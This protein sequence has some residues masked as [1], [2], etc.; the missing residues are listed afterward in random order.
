M[1]IAGGVEACSS[2]TLEREE[3][4]FVLR[5]LDADG[6]AGYL[7][8]W[9][10]EEDLRRW[11]E[12]F[13]GQVEGIS[14]PS[15][16]QATPI[17]LKMISSEERQEVLTALY[18]GWDVL[19]KRYDE[20]TTRTQGLLRAFL[21]GG[22]SPPVALRAPTE[23]TVARNLE[24]S[25]RQWLSDS[26]T[27]LYRSLLLLADEAKRLDLPQQAYLQDLLTGAFGMR[28]RRL[29]ERPDPDRLR[30]AQEVV[31]LADRMSYTL[32]RP[33]SVVLMY[34]L[35]THDVPPLIEQV[36]Q[37]ES[38]EECDLVSAVLRLSERFGF[39]TGR[40]RQRLRP[41]EERLAADP[42]LWP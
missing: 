16:T 31:D 23:F 4:G 13:K 33:E 11:L 26:G 14:L 30:E 40:L 8:P 34:E 28:L 32:D 20:L 2:L 9:R 29:R 17:S 37:T 1:M 18:R 42:G 3:F 7:F 19:R 38:R 12:A 6:M 15:H 10:G 25:L 35:L 5:W 21:E 22:L 24:E 41:F 39:S 27:D 36:L